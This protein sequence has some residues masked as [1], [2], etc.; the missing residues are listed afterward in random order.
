MPCCAGR[1]KQILTKGQGTA[2]MKLTDEQVRIIEKTLAKGDRVEIIPTKD[3]YKLFEATRKLL[4]KADKPC[5]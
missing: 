4:S 1:A 3:G 5:R 2:I